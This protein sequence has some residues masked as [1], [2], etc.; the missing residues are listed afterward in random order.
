V[1]GMHWKQ[2]ALCLWPGL[3]QLWLSGIWSG[4]VLAAGFAVLFDLLLVASFVWVEWLGPLE[5]RLGWMAAGSLWGASAIR[6]IGL[7]AHAPATTST[8]R[9]YR[10]ALTEYLQGSCFEAEAILGR[11]LRLVPRD[12]EGRLLLATVLRRTQRHDEALEQL[13]RLERLR[14]AA[15]WSR[16]I[17][18]ER[19]Q[20]AE[21]IAAAGLTDPISVED[22]A[23]ELVARRA[24]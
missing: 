22:L 15:R 10:E 2:L 6:S 23:D 21:A 17:A 7:H 8:D 9:L 13:D 5:L 20:I 19:Q 16:E 24:A 12:T 1:T 4:L 3:P 11:L 18:D 14:D